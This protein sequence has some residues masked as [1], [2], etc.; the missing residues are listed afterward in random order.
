M[1]K[2]W[3]IKDEPDS[4]TVEELSTSLNINII[5][6][7]LLAQR[8]I[9]TFEKA[10]NFFRPSI[11]DLHDPFLMKDMNNA[12]DRIGEAIKAGEKVMIYGDYDVD[13]TTSVAMLYSFFTG[14][15]KKIEYYIPDRYNEGYGISQRGI[16]YASEN[17]ISLI[18]TID[19]GI[20]A[21]DEI[22]Y[23]R[24]KMIDVIICDHHF[25]GEKIPDAVAV[26]NPKQEKCNYPYKHLSGC[27]VGFKMIQAFS[28][29]NNIKFHKL[30]Q[31]FDLLCLSIASDLVPI[32][33]ENRIFAHFGLIRLQKYPRHFIGK[34]M[35]GSGTKVKDLTVTDIIFKIGPRINAAG[36]M[37][38]GK[39]AVELILAKDE[40][41]ADRLANIIEDYNNS[42]K[43]LDASITK[44]AITLIR[45]NDVLLERKTTVLYDPGWHK[46]VIGIVASRLIEVFYRPTVI[47]T[48]SNDLVTGSARSVEGYDI[49]GAIEHC[50]KYLESFGG[51]KYAAGLTMK[52]E[53]VEKFNERFENYVSNNIKAEQLKARIEIDLEISLVNINS[54]FF[55]ILKQFC[56]FGF[57]NI[58]PVFVSHNVYGKARK[59]GKLE[60]H[61]K[62]DIYDQDGRMYFSGIAFRHAD[63]YDL[64][65]EDK[66]FSICYSIEENTFNNKTS[67]QLMIQDI[68]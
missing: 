11:S 40:Q 41:S 1:R 59:V 23:A 9:Y 68:H 52:E 22:N 54:G 4:Q 36:R 44:N 25:P 32:T 7:K 8:G 45:E 16:E 2:E 58:N 65:S 13:G 33:G 66:P 62:L 67:I 14:K 37:D 30:E 12:V 46:G 63:K 15:F 55:K 48:K 5:L 28:E 50:S 3:I 61:L 39:K 27:G 24:E 18:I 35:K 20:K 56:P 29:K 10:H 19:C 42:R 64:I 17:N 51:H 47:L 49:Y 43:K 26:L 38:T 53:N 21:N 60:E 57:G 31:Y 6:S 34:I